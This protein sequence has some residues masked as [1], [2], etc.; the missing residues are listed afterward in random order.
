MDTASKRALITKIY[1]IQFIVWHAVD[2]VNALKG[3]CHEMLCWE[4]TMQWWIRPKQ[5]VANPFPRLKITHLKATVSSVAHPRCKNLFSSS[6]W[7]CYN[8]ASTFPIVAYRAKSLGISRCD[9]CGMT[10]VTHSLWEHSSSCFLLKLPKVCGPF[11]VALVVHKWLCDHWHIAAVT[12][13]YTN[14]LE[15]KL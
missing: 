10:M 3:Q 11:S 8:S 7:F 9:G 14:E 5:M 12:A 15:A 2:S 6:G 1:I 4:K 13:R